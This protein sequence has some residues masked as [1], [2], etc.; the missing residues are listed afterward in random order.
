[1]NTLTFMNRAISI[2]C[3]CQLYFMLAFAS[4]ILHLMLFVS[5]LTTSRYICV[6]E[7]AK[8]RCDMVS[9]DFCWTFKIIKTLKIIIRL[10]IG[11]KVKHK[12]RVTNYEFKSRSYEFKSRSYKFKSTSYKFKFTS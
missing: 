12:L 11:G 3:I 8:I 10:Y 1:M 5:I 9:C 2:I 4:V 6:C 7:T